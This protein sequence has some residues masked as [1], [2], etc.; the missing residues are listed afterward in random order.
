[1]GLEPIPKQLILRHEPVQGNPCFLR[2]EKGLLFRQFKLSHATRRSGF[3]RSG[4]GHSCLEPPGFFPQ[5][6]HSRLG[7]VKLDG[8]LIEPRTKRVDLLEGDGKRLV[9]SSEDIGG[10]PGS[11]GLISAGLGGRVRVKL[12]RIRHAETRPPATLAHAQRRRTLLNSKTAFKRA[13]IHP[14]S[15]DRLLR[16]TKHFLVLGDGESFVDRWL[17]L[18]PLRPVSKAQGGKRLCRIVQRA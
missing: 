16:L 2:G 3:L 8:R 5:A 18:D 9:G 1:M 11:V 14:E 10:R 12:C 7:Q 17:V 6:L 13:A 4:C 15:A